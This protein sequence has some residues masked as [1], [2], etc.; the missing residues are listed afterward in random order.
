MSSKSLSERKGVLKRLKLENIAIILLGLILL[1]QLSETCNKAE[2]EEIQE[3]KTSESYNN[4]ATTKQGVNEARR[5]IDS[6]LFG[7]KD[8][9]AFTKNQLNAI[10][11]L[12][13]EMVKTKDNTSKSILEYQK[14]NSKYSQQL[15]IEKKKILDLMPNVRIVMP[16]NTSDTSQIS[17]QF[18]LINYGNRIADSV[19]FAAVMILFDTSNT[20]ISKITKVNS[21]SINHNALSLPPDPYYSHV[22]NSLIC[23]KNEIEKYGLGFLIVKYKYYDFITNA[24]IT[25]PVIIFGCRSLKQVNVQYVNNIEKNVIVELKKQ[26]ELKDPGLYKQFL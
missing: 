25:P 8:Q 18:Q 22:T 3:I 23:K 2:K 15:E 10:S 7:L 24:T 20:I 16:I 14:L 5:S 1:A 6:I 9:I 17:Y 21:N 13:A 26:L 11:A 12:N 4:I 19:E